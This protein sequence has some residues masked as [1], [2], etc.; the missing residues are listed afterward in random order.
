MAELANGNFTSDG[1]TVAEEVPKLSENSQGAW[2][3]TV[4][5]LRRLFD[6]WPPDLLVNVMGM[7]NAFQSTYDALP[8]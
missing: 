4:A 7:D 5:S 6:K 8:C 2:P 3:M 1:P